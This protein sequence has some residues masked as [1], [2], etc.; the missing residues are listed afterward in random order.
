V[1]ERSPR[2]FGKETKQQPPVRRDAAN[3]PLSPAMDCECPC[4]EGYAGERVPEGRVRGASER[5]LLTIPTS[6]FE[7]YFLVR[8]VALRRRCLPKLPSP[9]LRPPSPPRVIR[10]TDPCGPCGGEGRVHCI[11]SDRWC[12]CAQPPATFCD[13]SGVVRPMFCCDRRIS[14]PAIRPQ[15]FA[16]REMRN[17]SSRF[18]PGNRLSHRS[19]RG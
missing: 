12:R 4:N 8:S 1:V 17:F 5:S 7:A 13:A 19:Q 9:S 18:S 2:A 15:C 14:S 10:C 16:Y 11:P 3:P 6:R